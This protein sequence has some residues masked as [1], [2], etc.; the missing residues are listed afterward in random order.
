LRGNW[1]EEPVKILF[2]LEVLSG[3]GE[4]FNPAKYVTRRE[5]TAMIVR[6]IKDIPE[7][8]DLTTRTVT[9]TASRSKLPEISPFADVNTDDSYYDEI[10]T[11]SMRG[12]IQGT[13]LTY[14]SPERHITS[15]EA[16]TMII[17]SIGLEGLASYPYAITQFADNDDIPSYARNAAAVAFRIGLVEGDNRGNFL[18][19]ENLTYERA[20]ALIY[21]LIKYM[22]EELVKDYRE[23]MLDF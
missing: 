1:A 11:A 7:D 21:R 8:P 14:F 16:V 13:G 19:N 15:A 12:I 6:A 9:S 2:S 10:K 3:S 18:P 23:R 22:G 5:F 20:S 4:N 17:R